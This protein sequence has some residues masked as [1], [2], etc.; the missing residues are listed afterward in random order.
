MCT[1]TC[2]RPSY[3]V[4]CTFYNAI[5]DS[6]HLHNLFG[7]TA[8]PVGG[9][10]NCDISDVSALKYLYDIQ[11]RI[12][13]EISVRYSVTHLHWDICTI[14]SD[15]STLRYLYD[16]QWRIY[17]DISVLYSVTYLHWDICMI[18]NYVSTL[19]YLYD[20]Q[21]RIC[22]ETSVW[23]SVT[24]LHWDI[25]MIFS[26]VSKLRYLVG[27]T[28]AKELDYFRSLFIFGYIVWDKHYY[29]CFS[30][31]GNVATFES[32]AEVNIAGDQRL[33]K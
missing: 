2:T 16:I 21:L 9:M 18:F 30:V 29:N 3:R 1:F 31:L 5:H 32:G 17:I 19:R 11:W 13:I 24:Y 15:T 33:Q 4:D 12:Y 28:L 10:N 6:M 26:D 7:I 22:I 14:F 23:Y 20:I 8:L 27:S 25:C